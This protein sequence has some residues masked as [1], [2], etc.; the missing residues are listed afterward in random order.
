M[1]ERSEQGSLRADVGRSLEGSSA[2]GV[3][4]L[5]AGGKIRG[6]NRKA[7]DLI[8][9]P[10]EGLLGKPS[11]EIFSYLPFPRAHD[12]HSDVSRK[13]AVE[14]LARRKDGAACRLLVAAGDA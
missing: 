10:E 9:W 6:W 5:D 13:R 1:S 8:G 14:V 4:L 11:E 12:A 3:L 7:L 2:V